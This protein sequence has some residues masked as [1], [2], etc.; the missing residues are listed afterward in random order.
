MAEPTPP[1]PPAETFS[2]RLIRREAKRLAALDLST[3]SPM[4]LENAL[5]RISA[6]VTAEAAEAKAK[7]A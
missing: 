6:E 3:S 2:E 1:V 4:G 5:A 7:D